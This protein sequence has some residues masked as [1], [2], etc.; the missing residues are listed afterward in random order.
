MCKGE[1]STGNDGSTLALKPMGRVNQSLK[2]STSGPTKWRL[3]T[4]KK[5]KEKK[6]WCFYLISVVHAHD[7]TSI[8]EVE[9]LQTCWCTT[10]CWSEHQF[11]LSWFVNHLVCSLVLKLRKHSII[12]GMHVLNL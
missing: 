1:Q 11:E 4:A 12:N 10:V 6:L 2:L 7:D 5:G 8:L 9:A 3:V